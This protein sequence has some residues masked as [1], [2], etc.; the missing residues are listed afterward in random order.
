VAGS[1]DKALEQYL[2]DTA[3]VMTKRLQTALARGRDRFQVSTKE[4][5]YD[6]VTD[7]DRALENS[8]WEEIHERF[9]EDGFLGEEQGWRLGPTSGRDWVVDPIDGTMNFVN[10]LPWACCSIAVLEAG[11]PTAGLIVDPYRNEVYLTLSSE[12]GSELNGRSR[13]VAEGSDLAGKVILLEVPSGVSFTVLSGVERAV[14]ERGGTA[15]VMGSGAL[16]MAMT[17]VGRVHGVVH[18]GPNAWDVAAGVA[19]VHHAGGVT[20]GGGGRYE[21]G[22]TGPLVAGNDEVCRVLQDAL[23]TC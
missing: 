15:R 10:G 9:P 7:I 5:A 18:S 17:A 22:G 14:R 21:L 3:A 11:R 4:G 16:A 1:N 13:T 19:L 20:L 6:I 8:L 12:G 23:R 2:L